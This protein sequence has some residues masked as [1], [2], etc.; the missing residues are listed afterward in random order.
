MTNNRGIDVVLNSL[1]ADSLFASWAIIASY[2][3]FIELGK[4]DIVANNSLPMR[5]FL[6]RATFTAMETGIWATEY[7]AEASR[8]INIS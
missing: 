7:G 1:S 6:Q 4:K 5:P 2:G 3:R 8:M